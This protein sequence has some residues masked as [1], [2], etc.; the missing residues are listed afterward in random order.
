MGPVSLL[1][2]AWQSVKVT[3]P[4]SVKFVKVPRER[5]LLISGLS[6]IHSADN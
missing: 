2:V 3:A 1:I 5:V 4:T 6:T